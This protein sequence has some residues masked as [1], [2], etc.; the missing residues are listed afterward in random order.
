M[1]RQKRP[2]PKAEALRANRTSNPRPQAVTDEVIVAADFFDP[3][4]LVQ[5]K[6]EMVRRVREDGASVSAAAS[7]FGFSRQSFYQAAA[8][9]DEGGLA[10][11]VPAKP[12]PRGAHKLT[13]DVVEHIRALLAA[14]PSL[15]AADLARAVAERFGR[16]VHPR[17]I[18]RALKRS[19]Q[20][21]DRSLCQIRL[22]RRVAQHPGVDSHGTEIRAFQLT[23]G[24]PLVYARSVLW[25]SISGVL[26]V[27]G[28]WTVFPWS[29]GNLALLGTPLCSGLEFDSSAWAM[30]RWRTPARY[31]AVAVLLLAC[32]VHATAVRRG[33]ERVGRVFVRVPAAGVL[34]VHGSGALSLGVDVG[35]DAS[36]GLV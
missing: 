10:A 6:Y 21:P 28:M 35:V 20:E 15:R 27:V 2:D 19:G 31:S 30:L 1:P 17:S 8:A 13:P 22:V 32:V 5:V 11:P 26:A 12:G 9:F 33:R 25:W 16:R 29:G 24:C 14:D 7:A 34:L 18:E 3:R 4:D 36:S 23:L